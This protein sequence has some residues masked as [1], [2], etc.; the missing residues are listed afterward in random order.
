MLHSRR[1]LR[2]QIGCLAKQLRSQFPDAFTQ[3]RSNTMPVGAEL[4]PLLKR[5]AAILN[6]NFSIADKFP[7]QTGVAVAIFVK[8]GNDLVRGAAPVKKPPSRVRRR[9]TQRKVC[10]FRLGSYQKMSAWSS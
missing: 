3:D 7:A 9:Q 1:A 6:L 2:S 10:K 8:R 5:G 4:A